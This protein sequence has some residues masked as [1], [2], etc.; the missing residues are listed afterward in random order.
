MPTTKSTE[1][2]ALR[3]PQVRV[4]KLLAKDKQGRASRKTIAEKAKIYTGHVFIHVGQAEQAGRDH[5][6]EKFGVR[7]L[8]SHGYVR[9]V[10]VKGDKDEGIPDSELIEITA[11]GR[12]ALDK[13]ERL[14]VR[15]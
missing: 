14:Q 6:E 2:P 4:L 8:I 11:A 12:K 15:D 5:T 9:I 10:K 13:H 3:V 7:S 1:R